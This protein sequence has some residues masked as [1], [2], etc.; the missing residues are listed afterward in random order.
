MPADGGNPDAIETPRH[1]GKAI[2]NTRN[3]DCKSLRQFSFKPARPVFGKVDRESLFI[4]FL[5]DSS[6]AMGCLCFA[7]AS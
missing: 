3:P 2:R 6:I 5:V 4:Q 7:V 1:K